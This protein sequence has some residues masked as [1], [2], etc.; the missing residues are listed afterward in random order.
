MYSV[1]NFCN[2]VDPFSNFF[3]FKRMAKPY[4]VSENRRYCRAS[5]RSC[6]PST[7]HARTSLSLSLSLH[8]LCS[9]HGE[10]GFRLNTDIILLASLTLHASIAEITAQL[11][12]LSYVYMIS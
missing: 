7:S 9:A 2:I 6:F 11:L 5:V 1:A 3:P 4:L 12:S 10:L 8:L